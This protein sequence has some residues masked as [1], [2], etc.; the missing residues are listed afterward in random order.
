LAD[1]PVLTPRSQSRRSGPAR[2]I[3]VHTY[4]GTF[5]HINSGHPG[6]IRL[7][8]LS[9]PKSGSQLGAAVIEYLTATS[10]TRVLVS[11]REAP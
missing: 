8:A 2:G 1:P 7:T 11:L 3:R 9:G 6:H 10:R 4:R 5:R